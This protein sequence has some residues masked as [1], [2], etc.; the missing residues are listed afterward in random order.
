[1]KEF[2]SSR[3]STL[4]LL[5]FVSLFSYYQNYYR[6]IFTIV[7]SGSNGS[8]C[9]VIFTPHVSPCFKASIPM[10]TL[11]FNFYSFTCGPS[12]LFPTQPQKQAPST[13]PTLCDAAPPHSLP[14]PLRTTSRPLFTLPSAPTSDINGGYQRVTNEAGK[15][16]EFYF[17][18]TF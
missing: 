3:F 8:S 18:K 9:S 6:F 16:S 12:F 11:F 14:L 13:S 4:V 5:L 7:C 15:H 17:L 2:I 1:M 10:N